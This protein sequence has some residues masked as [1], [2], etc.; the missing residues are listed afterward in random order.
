MN[1]SKA[2][3]TLLAPVVALLLWA[4][5]ASADGPLLRDEAMTPDAF[6]A[7]AERIEQAMAAGAWP[8]LGPGARDEISLGLERIA[9]WLDDGT[10]AERA[11]A[12]NE[13]LRINAL[14]APALSASNT[15]EV[16]CR[17]VKA[18]GSNI[19]STVCH[20]REALEAHSRDVQNDLIRQDEFRVGGPRVDE[21][22]VTIQGRNY[23]R[24]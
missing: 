11:L 10:D 21:T 2:R 19:P 4:G 24:D 17:R 18:V 14:L 16:V 1:A 22:N 5:A 6:P 23:G 20:R 9:G 15:S 13:Q 8:R 12:R 7:E 3:R